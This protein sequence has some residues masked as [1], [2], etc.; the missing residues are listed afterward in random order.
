MNYIERVE[1]ILI[2]HFFV[3][4]LGINVRSLF[5]EERKSYTERNS[6][7]RTSGYI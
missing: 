5:R 3:I 1:M 6:S 7:N 2:S 4:D